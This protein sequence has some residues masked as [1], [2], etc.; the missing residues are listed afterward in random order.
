MRIRPE[1]LA[2][3]ILLGSLAALP[4]LSI[5]MGLPALGLLET[6][7]QAT[8]SQA[9]LTLSLFLTGFA[10][11]QLA[12]GPLSDEYGR[13]PV[14]MGGLMLYAVSSL[15]CAAAPS[16]G[17]LLGFRLLA[18]VGAAGAT[19][20]ALA[21]ARDVFEGHAARV[22]MSSITMVITIA[23]IVAP[24]L[25]GLMLSLGGWRFIYGLLAASGCLLLLLVAGL[26][27]ETR[28]PQTGT[29]LDIAK[30]Y[31][32]VLRQ[33]RTMGYAVVAAMGS[34]SLFAF[35]ANSPNVLME[36]MGASAG[37]FGVLFA[38]T[39]AGILLGSSFNS[40]LAH[41]RV[42]PTVPLLLGMV[43]APC[44]GI[45][46]SI[47]LL[48]GVERLET[49]VPFIVLTGFCRGL[50]NPNCTY[51]ALEPVPNHA[52]SA[53]AL[54]GCGQMLMAAA[55]GALVAAMYPWLGPLAITLAI[56][57]FGLAALIGWIAVER[58]FP[59]G[60]EAAD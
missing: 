53:S 41:R 48:L 49:F 16:I 38:I 54:I 8:A 28:P 14:M 29:R 2:F 34:G 22:R 50:V 43:L 19:T 60:G 51:A 39:S 32:A 12:A 44:S 33:R 9:T 45:G 21:V 31:G 18:G 1:S 27:P 42:R 30:R 52:G 26:L 24:T 20:L 46:A 37:L 3:T 56:T 4:P 17:V 7:L 36:H 11:A 15:C 35:I 6:S 47:F 58:W 55:S 23:P 13:R 57:G 25:G 10:V 59:A 40:L 5:E